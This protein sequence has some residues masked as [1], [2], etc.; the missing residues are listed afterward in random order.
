MEKSKPKTRTKEMS[1][2]LLADLLLKLQV[3]F[4]CLS[5]EIENKG[6]KVKA[7]LIDEEHSKMFAFDCDDFTLCIDITEKEKEV[8]RG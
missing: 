5:E 2:S 7:T 4:Y 6:K 8:C 3:E 1:Y